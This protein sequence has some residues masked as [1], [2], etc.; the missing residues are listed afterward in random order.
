MSLTENISDDENL[1]GFEGERGIKNLN[2]IAEVL[3]YQG[4]DLLYGTPLECFL[5]DNPGA[6]QALLEFI[7]AHAHAWAEST[8]PGSEED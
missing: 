2:R 5:A 4:H 6:Q 8:S 1:R 7:D 3:G